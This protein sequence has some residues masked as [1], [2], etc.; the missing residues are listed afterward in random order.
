VRLV[1]LLAVLTALGFA[2]A[3]FPRRET[4][5]H[6]DDL[7]AMQGMWRMT[8]YDS[9]GRPIGHNYKVRIKGNRWTFIH[10]A[11]GKENETASYVYNLDYKVAPRAFEWKSTEKSTSGWVG[12]YRL[13]GRK[14]TIIFGS[15]TLSTVQTRPTDFNGTPTYRMELE[16]IGR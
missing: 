15:G 10:L 16:F 8:R 3:P 6:R 5:Q 12:S 7:E 4:R 2:P 1:V 9:S 11:N 13:E 14:L